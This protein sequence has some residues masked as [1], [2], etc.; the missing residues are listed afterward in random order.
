[1]NIFQQ[2][3]KD[4]TCWSNTVINAFLASPMLQQIAKTNFAIYKREILD[5]LS[6]NEQKSFYTDGKTCI[7]PTSLESD[8]NRFI[9]MQ[10]IY[11]SLCHNESTI[12][13]RTFNNNQKWN[14][15]AATIFKEANPKLLTKL[16]KVFYNKAAIGL[17]DWAIRGFLINVYGKNM[18]ETSVMHNVNYTELIKSNIRLSPQVEVI[19]TKKFSKFPIKTVINDFHIDHVAIFIFNIATVHYVAGVIC[20]GKPYIMDSAQTILFNCDWIN[21]NFDELHKIYKYGY[22][23]IWISYGCYIKETILDANNNFECF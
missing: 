19:L 9:I 21:G 13:E 7:Y 6:Q 3:D 4:L 18:Y 1:M 23:K 10:F 17:A 2:D 16:S 20:D 5:N 22:T 12:K 8:I 11:K 15:T 14:T